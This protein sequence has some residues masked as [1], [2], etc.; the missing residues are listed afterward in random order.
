MIH[1]QNPMHSLP[2]QAGDKKQEKKQQ[3][4]SD[5]VAAPE[6]RDRTDEIETGLCRVVEA[7]SDNQNGRQEEPKHQPQGVE[8]EIQD[9]CER[10][11]CAF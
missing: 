2:K 5:P 7:P 10:G 3:S 11:Q 1:Q 4:A 6:E 9:P 8:K